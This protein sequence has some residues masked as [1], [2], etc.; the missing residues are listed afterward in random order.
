MR[1]ELTLSGP[2]SEEFLMNAE[3]CLN[4]GDDRIEDDGVMSGGEEQA[5]DV[6]WFGSLSHT[7]LA[8]GPSKP[9]GKNALSYCSNSK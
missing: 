2:N 9:P 6:H 8:A 1:A 5:Q 4:N 3:D 7:R